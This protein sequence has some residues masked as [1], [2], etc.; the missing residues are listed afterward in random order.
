MIDVRVG[1]DARA[2][3]SDI[4][5][6]L[7]GENVRVQTLGEGV[8]L[9]GTVSTTSVAARAKAMADK[10]APDGATSALLVSASQEVVLEVRVMEATRSSLQD[11]GFAGH[12]HQRQHH[13]QLRHGLIGN[14]PANGVAAASP[15]TPGSTA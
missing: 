4:D 12:D 1:Y 3:Q 8:L 2:L 13:D 15:P 9:T 7:P 14:T 6:A 11:V 10:F 5:T